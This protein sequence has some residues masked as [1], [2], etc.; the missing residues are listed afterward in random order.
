M[1]CVCVA[2]TSTQC[3]VYSDIQVSFSVIVNEKQDL[4][5][6]HVMLKNI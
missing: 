2:D 6:K 1:V 5:D 3:T 4:Q